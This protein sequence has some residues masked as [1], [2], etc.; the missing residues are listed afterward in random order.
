M[1]TVKPRPKSKPVPKPRKAA[2]LFAT[3]GELLDRLGGITPHR[4]CADPPPG[5]ATLRDFTRRDGRS[6]SGAMCELID[7]TLVEK[8]MGSE[9]TTLTMW[10]G[11]KLLNYLDEHPIAFVSGETYPLLVA[12]GLVRSPDISV[13]LWE[14]RPD[15]TIP[16]GPVARDVPALAI[17]VISPSNTPGEMRRKLAHYFAAGVKVVWFVDPQ[18]Y[19]GA[20][21][22]SPEDVTLLDETGVLTAESVL[23][24]FTLPLSV[25][26]AQMP[27]PAAKKRKPKPPPAP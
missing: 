22:T 27:K 2:P 20:I 6:A 11:H 3:M 19:S 16:V 9:Q 23:P 21:Y 10:I 5:T 25:V 15:G 13:V 7:R 14:S 8:S 18:K 12:P 4:V 17:E 1:P 26:F 24:G